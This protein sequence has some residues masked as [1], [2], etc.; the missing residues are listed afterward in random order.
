MYERRM[1]KVT[2]AVEKH[3]PVGKRDRGFHEKNGKAFDL[4][5]QGG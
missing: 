1:V 4:E 3:P 2:S 5:F